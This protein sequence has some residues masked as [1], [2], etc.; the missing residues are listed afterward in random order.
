MLVSIRGEP[1][2]PPGCGG[3]HPPRKERGAKAPETPEDE[4]SV[5]QEAQAEEEGGAEVE[6]G[7]KPAPE[8]MGE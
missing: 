5:A 3:H 4:I 2:N 1:A 6:R 7:S 8:E